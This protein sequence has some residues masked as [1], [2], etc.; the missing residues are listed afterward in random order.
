V[1]FAGGKA[2][3][4]VCAQLPQGTLAKNPDADADTDDP[5]YIELLTYSELDSLLEFHGHIRLP[6]R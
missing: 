6:T 4:I 3:T 5:G 2:I 1:A